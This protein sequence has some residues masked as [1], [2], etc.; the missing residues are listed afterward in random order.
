MIALART[1]CT[2]TSYGI[3]P[4]L[5]V[6]VEVPSEME[7]DCDLILFMVQVALCTQRQR[8]TRL[9]LLKSRLL[10][11]PETCS[12]RFPGS[13]LCVLDRQLM[14]CRFSHRY[15][16]FD[17]LHTFTFRVLLS[18]RQLGCTH[19]SQYT[20]ER[21]LCCCEENPGVTCAHE[22]LQKYSECAQGE[23]VSHLRSECC[24][25]GSR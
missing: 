4:W 13:S 1:A 19:R 15:A 14:T 10:A 6:L 16:A 23:K 8:P 11:V 2:T 7:W 3:I 5:L 25:R 22:P 20:P 17:L 21:P 12:T 18:V 24:S 9:A